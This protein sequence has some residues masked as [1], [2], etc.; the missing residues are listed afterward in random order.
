VTPFR[1]AVLGSAAL[2]AVRLYAASRVG[3]GDA[4]ALYACY[5]MH[6][7]AVYVDHPGLVGVFA[8]IVG[9]GGAPAPAAAHTVTAVVSTSIPWIA[10]LAARAVG[11]SWAGAGLCALCM[12]VAP[13]IAI[14]TFGMTPDLAL[15]VL[16]Y[17]AMAFA[18]VALRS[19]PGSLLALSS[20]LASGFAAGLAFDSKATGALLFAGLVLG[21]CTRR[22]RPHVRTVAPWAALALFSIVVSPV[23]VEEVGRGFPML[24]HRLVETQAGAG[25][26]LRNIGALVGGQLLYVTPPLLLGAVLVLR[27]L[28]RRRH[29]DA[30]TGLLFWVTAACAPLLI[31]TLV[32][33]V[34][35]PHWLAPIYL[36][37]PLSFALYP[38]CVSKR[39][40]RTAAWFGA[41]AIATVHLWV[42]CPIGPRLLGKH[43]RGRYDLANDLYAW[44]TGLALLHQSLD[45]SPSPHVVVVGP[46][47]SICA[48]LHAG[49]G[50]SVPVGCDAALRDDFAD[51]LPRSTWQS[52]PVVLYV[53]DDRF[54]ESG[55]DLP[56]RTVDGVWSAGVTRAGMVVRRIRVS[57]MVRRGVATEGS[58]ALPR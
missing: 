32:S 14:G 5:A 46:H 23:V 6:P 43:Y 30:V 33:R 51:W 12:T 27:D 40:A 15:I 1:I 24:R 11:A 26:S 36:A 42:L 20:T 18:A 31:L 2:L 39:L 4:E 41:C 13:E 10:A 57:R 44:Q 34:A 54:G 58:P 52:A 47:Y 7:Q 38:G 19:P 56:N 55:P 48:Q 29:A 9:L 37:L 16:W 8:R 49:L 35:E 22:A 45:A 50:P 25:P 21:F 53:T 3:F 17:A 28:A